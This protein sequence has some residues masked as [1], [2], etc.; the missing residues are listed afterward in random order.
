M[1]PCLAL[2]GSS[3]AG[4]GIVSGEDRVLSEPWIIEVVRVERGDIPIVPFSRRWVRGPHRA[5]TP[6][7]QL[8]VV[9]RM[10]E[11]HPL[12]STG[13]FETEDQSIRVIPGPFITRG[14]LVSTPSSRDCFWMDREGNP[15]IGD[16][17]LN[18]S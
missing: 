1:L 9:P 15:R 8:A 11:F 2:A 7:E 4:D 12:R 16:C 3:G 5:G 14:E 6:T 18:F 13:D 10:P 17:E